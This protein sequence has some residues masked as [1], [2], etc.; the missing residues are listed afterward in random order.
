MDRTRAALLAGAA[1]AVEISGTRITMAQVAA[2][3]GVAKATLYNHFRTRETVLGALLVAQVRALVDEQAGKLLGEALS[4]AAVAI[5]QHPL[6]RALAVAEPAAIATI[7][8]IDRDA[9][10]WQ[11]AREAVETALAGAALDTAGGGGADVVLRWLASFLLSPADSRSIAV[12]VDVLLA[13]LAA[14][15]G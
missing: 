1:R 7:A 9:Q 14:R 15:A 3:A 4:A 10:G 2:A 8:T 6:R 11:V 12:D 5:S 13:G